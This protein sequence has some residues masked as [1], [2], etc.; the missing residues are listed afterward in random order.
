M[1][2]LSIPLISPSERIAN[3][4][5]VIRNFA[6]QV[7]LKRATGHRNEYG[8]WVDDG[9]VNQGNLTACVQ[10]FNRQLSLT[11]RDESFRASDLE[12][13]GVRPT[14]SL[15]FYISSNLELFPLRTKEDPL[16]E[17]RGDVLTYRNKEYRV[18]FIKP[19]PQYRY[20]EVLAIRQEGRG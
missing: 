2:D 16:G 7:S 5:K 17:A 6:E 19:F 12:K 13:V 1:A 15:I 18:L 3:L 20:M 8:E 4:N 9:Y 14:E 10:P 11:A